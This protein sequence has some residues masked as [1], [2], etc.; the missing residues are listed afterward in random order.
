[1]PFPHESVRPLAPGAQP[2]YDRTVNLAVERRTLTVGSRALSYLAAG[3][4]PGARLAIFLHAFPL[5]AEMWLPQLAALPPGW[6]AL[7]P[8]FRGFGASDPDGDSLARADARLEDYAADVGALM[9]ALGRARAAICGCSMG[10]YAAFAL[11]RRY[12]GRVAGLLLADTRATADSEAAQASRGAM[13]QLLDSAGPAAVAAEMRP[14]LVGPTSANGRPG[15][16]AAVDRLMEGA[17]ARGVGFA[18]SRIRNRPDATAELAA[19]GAPLSVVVGEED[20][21][22]PPSEA[23]SMAAAVP[24]A[25]LQTIPGA[26]HLSN[27]E[28]PDAFN[29]ALRAW[30]ESVERTSA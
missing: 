18:I 6:G 14:K 26:G 1:M 22:T 11:L 19:F 23:A 21:L 15:V 5:N 20:A 10:G 29:L 27:L 7:A 4:R 13:L 28:A 30:L 12:P 8:D 2:Q 17:T 24:G 9:D 25:A 3:D 16:M